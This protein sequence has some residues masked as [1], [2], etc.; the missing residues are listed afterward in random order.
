MRFFLP[1]YIKCELVPC[2]V[3]V[4]IKIKYILTKTNERINVYLIVN[5]IKQ[6]A[7]ELVDSHVLFNCRPIKKRLFQRIHLFGCFSNFVIEVYLFIF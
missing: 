1:N 7:F 4:H 3:A 6:G 5:L 2:S